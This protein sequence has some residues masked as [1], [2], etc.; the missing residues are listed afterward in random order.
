MQ[1]ALFTPVTPSSVLYVEDLG[2]STPR[3]SLSLPSGRRV[4]ADTMHGETLTVT[5]P[6]G[7]LEL[8][9]R[10]TPE[11]PTLTLHAKTLCLRADK[12]LSI[13]CDRFALRARDGVSIETPKN[14]SLRAEGTLS[15]DGESIAIEAH[16]SDVSVFAKGEVA[17]DGE[18]IKLG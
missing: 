12:D 16:Q 10:F 4:S 6:E 18:A 13:D 15:V 5:S 17:I 9:V 14:L 7:A 1:R 3:E 8:T 11:G 2:V